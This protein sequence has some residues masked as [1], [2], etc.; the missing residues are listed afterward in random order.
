MD[1]KNKISIIIPVYNEAESIDKLFRELQSSIDDKY[2][3]EIIF[4]N[5][6]S[7]DQSKNKILDIISK[8]LI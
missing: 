5:D 2:S 7:F 8:N 6:G 3:Y 4:I 1:K